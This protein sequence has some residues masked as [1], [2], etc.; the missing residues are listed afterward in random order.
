M[1]TQLRDIV[2]Q[3]SRVEH[4]H[5][6]LDVLVNETCHA[7]QTEC[8]TVYFAN[9]ELSRLEL[10]ATKGLKFEGDEIH[11]G[12]HEGLVGLVRRT[13]EPLNL[14]EV[15]THPSFKFFPQ[16]GEGIYHSFLGAP[17][18]HRKQVLGVLVIQQKSPRLFSEM[19]ESF[20]VTLSAQ[21][22]VIIAHAQAQGHWL[23]ND[24]NSQKLSGIAAS[25]GVA[26]GEFWWDDTQPKL[27]DVYPASTLDVEQ[28]QEWL[29]LAMESAKADFRRL[30]KKLDNDINKDTLAIFDLFT[31]LL[32][33]PMLRNDLKEQIQKGDR[34]DWA[35][36]QVVETYSNRFAQMSD[37]Y[38][39][40]RA[41]DIRELGQRLLYF[42]H[43]SEVGELE[44]NQPVILVV[45]ELTASTLASLPKDKLLAVISIEGAAN[46]H[47]AI[48]SRALG[49]PAIMGAN[50]T[51][52]NLNGKE[53]IVD[54]YSGE[55]F[56]E[57]PAQLLKEYR[58]LR[59]E[60]FELSK[61]VEK[62]L[63]QEAK[64]QDDC[65]VDVLLN[66]GL[67]ADTN[68]SVNQGVNG[69]GLYRT[70]ISF[71]LQHRFPSEEE[72]HQQY[73]RVLETY[74][75]KPVVMRTLDVGGDK[76]LPYLPI[77]ED[78]PFLGWRGIRFTLDHPDIFLIQLRAM[79]K[80]SDGLNNLNILLPMLSGNQELDD[81]LAL[82]QQ[83]YDEVSQ[84]HKNVCKPRVGVML[85]VPSMLYL[86]SFMADKIDFVSV[87][88]NDLT[89]YLLAV[90]RNNARVSGVYESVHPAV[91][92]A[93]AQIEKTC[94]A[95]KLPVSICGELA[96][97]PIGALLLVGLGYRSL[98]MNTANV[99]RVKYLL[100]QSSVKDL[101]QLAL[102][103][104]AQPYGQA[105][106]DQVFDYL[107]QRNLAGFVRA[108]NK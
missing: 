44:L 56:V 100:R 28:E 36:R 22:A 52:Q 32:N 85:E 77:E 61:M 66:A 99:A 87:G 54:G 96:G 35:L 10:M 98:S 67:S 46:S 2:E 39:R 84:S 29:A 69:V 5:E 8:C 60:E 94:R 3:V 9:D 104:L 38:L 13:A 50:V 90:D 86:L 42:L 106:Y 26:V 107:E 81:A 76:P 12:Y 75:N 92:Q 91:I 31:H 34:A 64:T 51:P 97:D 59:D 82:I 21:L 78:N 40:E 37:V 7:M 57:P 49:I 24:A 89:Q 33:D 63:H 41:Q 19:E 4:I 15:S 55:I 73:R 58:S 30:R 93:L 62:E 16:L 18:I 88:T 6:A 79:L 71:L 53:G 45:N 102:S 43:T 14:A 27:S 48:L 20:L 101:E 105:I 95:Y 74:P 103:A 11:I 25:P 72:Q 80:A 23:L 108:G 70:E 47:A 68:I 65:K 17:I 83:A 1:L